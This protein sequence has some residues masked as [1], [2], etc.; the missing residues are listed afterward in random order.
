M[1]QTTTEIGLHSVCCVELFR[2]HYKLTTYIYIYKYHR[3]NRIWSNSSFLFVVY[4]I[5][6]GNPV[7]LHFFP[8]WSPIFCRPGLAVEHLPGWF[9]NVGNNLLHNTLPSISM[10]HT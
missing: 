7:S 5:V 1:G 8:N 6:V 9:P 4:P 2:S 3:L 10:S